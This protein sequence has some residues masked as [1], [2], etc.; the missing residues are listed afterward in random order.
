MKKL[1]FLFLFL[2]IVSQGY[3]QT[4]FLTG[5]DSISALRTNNQ[6]EYVYAELLDSTDGITDTFYVETYSPI[7]KSWQG[8]RVTNLKSTAVTNA[9]TAIIIADGAYVYLQLNE[10]YPD[11]IRIKKQSINVKR[12]QTRLIPIKTQ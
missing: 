5:T 10:L 1:M 8:A 2:F 4:K 7:T 3:S 6:F 12:L 9:G 11:G